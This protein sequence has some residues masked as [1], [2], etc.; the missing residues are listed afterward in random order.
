M[1]YNNRAGDGVTITPPAFNVSR[2]KAMTLDKQL[3]RAETLLKAAHE[4]L[5]KCDEGPFVLNALEETIYYDDAECD[6]TC[7]LEDIGSWFEEIGKPISDC[8]PPQHQKETMT[9]QTHTQT[10]LNTWAQS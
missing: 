9:C 10:P 3:A 8:P 6:G 1:I 4:L 5:Q 7:L 2:E